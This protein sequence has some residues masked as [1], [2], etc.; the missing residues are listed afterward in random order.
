MDIFMTALRRIFENF[1][2]A[3]KVSI[4]P[5]FIG[6][7][8]SIAVFGALGLGGMML[9][10]ATFDPES[11]FASGPG[12]GI[13]VL[14]MILL[15]V[16]WLFIFAWIAVSWHRASL[17]NSPVSFIP[18]FS[19]LP[20]G[21]YIM[22]T[23]LLGLVLLVTFIVVGVVFGL[24]AAGLAQIGIVGAI[25]LGLIGLFLLIYFTAMW[26]RMASTL[27]GI[28]LGH[29]PA[30]GDGWSQTEDIKR[31]IFWAALATLIFSFLIGL[32]QIPFAFIPLLAFVVSIFLSWLQTI[33]GVSMLTEIYRRTTYRPSNTEIFE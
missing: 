9:G 16:F 24:V 19:G 5:F 30:F 26:F 31:D 20:L 22:R 10:D 11:L 17:E 8:A 27:P 33:L 15:A 18:Q 1:N 3:L 2:V 14:G 21:R 13:A 4:V 32:V 29:R 6:T 25:I 23:I 28:A 12:I 7:A